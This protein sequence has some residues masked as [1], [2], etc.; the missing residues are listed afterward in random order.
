MR[1]LCLTGRETA[2]TRNEVLLRAFRRF[3]EVDVA[4]EGA[5]GGILRRSLSLPL[6]ALARLRS[7]R[8]NLVFVGFFGQLLM[9]AVSRLARAP[10]LFDAFISAWDTLTADRARFAPRS[11][12]G[13]LAFRLDETACARAAHVL[14]DTPQH[15][16]F[17]ADTFGI[18]PAKISA[19]PVGCN[20]DLFHPRAE[21]A[22]TVLYYTS[23]Q[24]LHGVDTVIRAA[25]LA[26]QARFKIIGDGQT[27][28]AARRLARELGV[29]NIHFAAPCP[30][31]RLPHEIASAAVCL[32]GHFGVSEKA[33]R[34]VP[35]KVYQIL[36]MGRPLVA[37]DTPANRDLLPEQ[38]AR[39]VQPADP[40]GLAQAIREILGDPAAGAALGSRGR[41]VYEA[42]ASERVITAQ[43]RRVVEDVLTP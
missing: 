2:Y 13:R 38:A 28:A 18:P 31:E 4:G 34:V 35:G 32:G 20:E 43:L 41:A 12:P 29:G 19:I 8:Y 33:R 26:P 24:P 16:Q 10:I 11:L 9:P 25:A 21:P 42:R 6:K 1:I 17:F 40:A 23:Y 36:A 27:Y 37:A 7:A 14:L 22:G 15:A 5:R 39:F 30:L 3:A